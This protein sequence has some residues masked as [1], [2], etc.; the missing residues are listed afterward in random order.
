L[1]NEVKVRAEHDGCSLDDAAAELLRKGLAAGDEPPATAPRPRIGA[2]PQSGLPFVEC[3]PEAPARRTTVP[4]LVALE[5]ETLARED[6]ERFG[7]SRRH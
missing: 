2:H 1:V 5:H 4:E 3:L 7:L 6:R